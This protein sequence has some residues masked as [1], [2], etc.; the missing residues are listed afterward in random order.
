[1]KATDPDRTPMTREHDPL[2]EPHPPPN[3][4]RHVDT[5]DGNPWDEL[6][7]TGLLW[8]INSSVF[9]PRGYQFGLVYD[10]VTGAC[11]GWTL[12][13]DGTEPWIFPDDDATRQRFLA[14]HEMMP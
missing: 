4:P 5:D 6:R 12:D 13:G 8:L 10:A 3:G 9:H 1:M 7:T 11:T 14:V 2:T